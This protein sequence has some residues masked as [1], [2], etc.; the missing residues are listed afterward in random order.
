V[1]A[2]YAGQDTS[3]G[4]PER[5]LALIRRG[6]ARAGNKD[7]TARIFPQA[8]H[9]LCQPGAKQPGPAFVPGYLET[10]TDWLARHGS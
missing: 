4:P 8:D 5:L 1:L 10:M 2:I 7:F 3:S 6:L 9:G